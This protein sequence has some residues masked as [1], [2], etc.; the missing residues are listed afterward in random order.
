[1]V[2][3]ATCVMMLA[4]CNG[5]PA[6]P[7]EEPPVR[8][9]VYDSRA[10]AVAFAG[11][12]PFAKWM[13]ALRTEH[14]KANAAG[15]DKRVAELKAEAASRQKLM[16]MQGFS[17]A[18]VDDVLEHIKDALPAIKDKAGVS[19][20]VSK[21]DADSLAKHASA[22]HVDVT[23]ALVD[24]LNPNDRQRKSAIEVQKHK[25]IPLKDAENLED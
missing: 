7:D 14:D 23:M 9:G 24:A 2:C 10:V 4:G 1:M 11:S 3:V 16:H 15:D 22:E 20:L 17:T 8:I 13:S 25:P 6:R 5:R 21:W 12:A 19:A 18:P